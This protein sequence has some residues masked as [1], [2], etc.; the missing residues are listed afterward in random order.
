MA[1]RRASKSRTA[2]GA[3]ARSRWGVLVVEVDDFHAEDLSVV[4][5]DEGL[6]S[7]TRAVSSGRSEVRLYFPST[8]L[9]RAKLEE[10]RRLLTAYA[11][12]GE[13][14]E[15]RV[16]QVEDRRWVE[17]FQASLR[18]FD[19]GTR[20]RV[21][22]EGGKRPETGPDRRCPILLVP[23]QAF[24]TGEHPTTRMCAALLE[25]KV[26][27]GERWVDLG[28]GTGILSV[29]AHHCG[30]AEVRAFD[31]DPQAVAVAREVL[32][33]NRLS[34]PICAS[35]GSIDE[36][37]K[38]EWNGV[39]ANI[40]LPFF[41]TEARGLAGLLLPGG[42]LIASGFLGRDVGDVTTAFDQAGLATIETVQDGPWAAIVAE[43]GEC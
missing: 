12:D 37:G 29:V 35:L 22:P 6:G 4:L 11:M 34:D 18:P 14:G 33:A 43:L 39:V 23:G 41:L 25:A 10:V 15:P 19:L 27:P 20:F 7:E 28:C 16:E 1:R 40:E 2:P 17:I 21:H 36:A 42:L 9:A 26:D 3:E 31:D 30:A 24:G 38:R 13:T 8:Q 32:A 5:G